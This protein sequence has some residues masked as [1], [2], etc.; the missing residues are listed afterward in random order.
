MDRFCKNFE[1]LRESVQTFV[2][3]DDKASMYSLKDL[4]YLMNVVFLCV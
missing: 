4:M 1:L 3:N 2:E